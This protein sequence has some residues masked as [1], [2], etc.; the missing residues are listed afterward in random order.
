MAGPGQRLRQARENLG[1][2]IR[3]V[4]SASQRIA[5]RKGSDEFYLNLSRISDIESKGVIPTI[6]RLYSLSVIYRVDLMELMEWYGVDQEHSKQDMTLVQPPRT[7]RINPMTRVQAVK[8]PV[9]LDP[10]FDLR[11]TTNIGRMV[12]K[13]G[14]VPLVFLEQFADASY[15]YGYI[16]SEDLTMYPLLLP[17]SFIKVD[18]TRDRVVEDVWRSEYERPIYFIESRDGFT[19][20]W[21]SI[22]NHQIYLQPHP[23]SPVGPRLMKYPQEAEVVGQV[24]GVAMSL[25]WDHG[26]VRSARTRQVL[27]PVD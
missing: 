26:S 21:V 5:Q 23:L 8:M 11:R 12:Q 24:V 10:Q 4:E 16:G 18:E 19:C 25:D 9:A 1:Y 17:G 15:T 14:V 6:Y 13:W 27:G 2:T 22:R 7:H 3:E 20:S